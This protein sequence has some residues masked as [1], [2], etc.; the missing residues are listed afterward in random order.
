M[1]SRVDSVV[2]PS[3]MQ[4][5]AASNLV[6]CCVAFM[7][8]SLIYVWRMA[9]TNSVTYYTYCARRGGLQYLWILLTC[10]AKTNDLIRTLCSQLD[11]DY[12]VSL[13]E[14]RCAEAESF[15]LEVQLLHCRTLLSYHRTVSRMIVSKE[16]LITR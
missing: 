7:L 14:Q 16:Y 11:A 6:S 9:T 4:A 1:L 2:D 5:A 13:T 8:G 10:Y 3:N 15:V 12:M